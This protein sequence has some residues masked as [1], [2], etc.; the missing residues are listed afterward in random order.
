M[1]P[2]DGPVFLD[3]Q[4]GR[5]GPLH[6]DLASLLFSPDTGLTDSQREPLVTDYLAALREQG[7]TLEAE[8]FLRDF[9]A[10]VL[11]RRLQALG[12]YARIAVQVG[13]PEYLAKIPPALQT[14]RDL[15]ARGR[16]ALGLPALEGWLRAMV[17]AETVN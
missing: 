5:R 14:L 12:A 15:F 1:W 17:D 11:M 2:S 8:P 9:Y 7:V 6:Y 16:L 3:Y 4:S 13:K 10:F